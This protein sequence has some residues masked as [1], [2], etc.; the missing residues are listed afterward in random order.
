MDIEDDGAGK[1]TDGA[2]RSVD[3]SALEANPELATATHVWATTAAILYHRKIV[4]RI[5]RISVGVYQSFKTLDFFSMPHTTG[6]VLVGRIILARVT[7]FC[8]EACRAGI[9]CA[10]SAISC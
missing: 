4:D 2:H 9:R 3:W 1:L 10:S 6:H 5:W 7:E 8:P